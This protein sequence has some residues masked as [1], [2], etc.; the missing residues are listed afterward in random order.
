MSIRTFGAIALLA[1]VARPSPRR[2]INQTRPLTADGQ[3]RI[4]NI[5]GSIVV[6]TWAKAAG[7]RH[8]LARQGRREAARSSGD[9]R[10]LDIQVKY[11]N[12]RGGWN[13]WGRDDNR[14]EP[15]ILEVMLP[16]RAS[17]DVDS[18]S[19]DVDVQQMAGRKLD[20][21]QR[22]RRRASS[23]PPRRARRSFE[24]VSGDTTLRITTQGPGPERQRRP[25]PAGRARPAR[26]RWKACPATSSWCA[27]DARPARGQHRF[28][29]RADPAPGLQPS[30]SIKAEIAQRRAAT[31]A[32]RSATGA[33]VHVE[34]FSGD[35]GSPTGTRPSRRARP[36]QVARHQLRRWPR[37]HRPGELLRQRAH[38]AALT[39][40]RRGWSV[41]PGLQA[42]AVPTAI[43]RGFRRLRCC[44]H[45]PG[46][47]A[48]AVLARYRRPRPVPAPALPS[49]SSSARGRR[50]ARSRP[51]VFR[52]LRAAAGGRS[53]SRPRSALPSTRSSIHSSTRRLSPKPGHRNRPS[54]SLRN[55]LTWKIFGSLRAAVAERQPVREVVADVVAAERH[56]RHRV[57][58]HDADRA[59]RG[60]GRLRGHRWRRRARRASSRAPRTPAAPAIRA[61]RRT[62]SPTAARPAGP[63]RCRCSSG[64]A[65]RDTVK[66]EFGCAAG[67]LRR[68]VRR[69]P[70]SR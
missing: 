26:S 41:R 45:Q 46:R 56:H 29:R 61:G 62:R 28:R 19:A 39:K 32:C 48:V 57:A 47:G 2:P 18:V 3:V 36:R 63:R 5:K 11:P 51:S 20:G 16:Q 40:R 13:L 17:L 7:A 42:I 31:C 14:T 35:I 10:S 4:E 38:R 65:A 25:A 49:T 1:V 27:K 64:T 69:G 24:N 37:P 52:S 66:R 6:R 12:S 67:P 23:P 43:S 8:R 55:Q 54:S 58:A 50:Q 21:L 22:Q 68:V 59:G 34:T 60:G 33:R 53:A 15:T 30:G 9:A 44:I 70:A